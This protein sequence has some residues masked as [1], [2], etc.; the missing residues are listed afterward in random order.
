MDRTSGEP[1]E[2]RSSRTRRRSLT[3]A[4][5]RQLNS[6]NFTTILRKYLAADGGA[7]T[8][9][10]V[11][12]GSANASSRTR[13]TVAKRL[14]TE[15]MNVEGRGKRFYSTRTISIYIFH[16]FYFVFLLIFCKLSRLRPARNIET[17]EDS[18][19]AEDSANLLVDTENSADRFHVL[20][21]VKSAD[22]RRRTA[23]ERLEGLA[24]N[25]RIVTVAADPR[26]RPR[27]RRL[28]LSHCSLY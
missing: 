3:H 18:E 23:E 14:S 11:P 7:I 6:T 28:H 13:G 20:P 17:D 5:Y 22:R 15:I 12:R 9:N 2:A 27:H 10:S 25:R 1:C 8:R 19:E 16:F 21:P 24:L 26:P 4:G